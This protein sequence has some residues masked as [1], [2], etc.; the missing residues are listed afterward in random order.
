MSI[1]TRTGTANAR[2]SHASAVPSSAC[3]WPS[4]CPGSAVM[5]RPEPSGAAHS[6]PHS[7]RARVRAE[8]GRPSSSDREITA[9]TS[10][11]RRIS[12]QSHRELTGDQN[13]SNRETRYARSTS[14]RHREVHGRSRDIERGHLLVECPGLLGRRREVPGINEHGRAVVL[15]LRWSLRLA[16][17]DGFTPMESR[18]PAETRRRRTVLASGHRA[19]SSNG[20]RRPA[21]RWRDGCGESQQPCGRRWPGPSGA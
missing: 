16:A 18:K 12:R 14:R 9:S 20:T 2:G 4:V 1:S 5:S 15:R 6:G 17:H 21:A 13:P 19:G 8:S 7:G 3:S 11:S 10:C